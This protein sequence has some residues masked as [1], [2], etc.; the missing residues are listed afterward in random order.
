MS[1]IILEKNS[2]QNMLNVIASLK[3]QFDI[4]SG[5]LPNN[6]FLSALSDF[7]ELGKC[8]MILNY[9]SYNYRYKSEEMPEDKELSFRTVT[10]EI[11]MSDICQALKTAECLS[12][13]SSDFDGYEIDQDYKT[14]RGLIYYLRYCII[15]SIPEYI[16]AKW[17]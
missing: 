12:Y 15:Q 10:K 11:K 8:L 9:R 1:C 16:T 17:G 2:V 5:F 14:L 7:D 3:R 6:C 13:N 4:I